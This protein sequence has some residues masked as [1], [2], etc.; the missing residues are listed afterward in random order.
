MS[1]QDTD[2]LTPVDDVRRVRQEI[3]DLCGG[4]IRKIAEYVNQVGEAVRE[5]LGSKLVDPPPRD[6]RENKV[7]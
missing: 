4:D 6:V 1:E 7:V 5:K 2:D 3:D